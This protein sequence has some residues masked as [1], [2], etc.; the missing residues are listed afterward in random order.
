MPAPVGPD[1]APPPA[2]LPVDAA[3]VDA[4]C[5]ALVPEPGRELEDFV[6][7]VGAAPLDQGWDNVLWPVGTVRGEPVV[8]RVV[9][10]ASAVP[11][12]GREILVL[13]HLADVAEQL[14]MRIPTPLATT[15]HATLVPWI[16]GRTAGEVEEGSRVG[17][18]WSVAR[19]LARVHSLPA[20]RVDPNPV[21][22]AP[23]ATRTEAFAGDLERSGVDAVTRRRARGG[24]DRG[25]GATTWDRPA[26]LMHGD[27][28]PG[29]VVVP[30]AGTVREAALIDWG[31]ATIGDPASD[32]GALLL[33]DPSDSMLRAYRA[34]A[35]WAGIADEACWSAL[36][37]RSWAWGVRL[38]LSLLTAY[39]RGH[40]LGRAGQRLLD[41]C[42]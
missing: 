12:L 23:L 13:R 39:P 36:V 41:A 40:R 35:T 21:R 19:M 37:D 32:L 6:T 3:R 33:H 30:P 25:L 15:D 2:D 29:N 16:P 20:P 14:P 31:D 8:L 17:V 42:R 5:A 24:W 4:L 9:R 18:A 28:H 22:G 11:L 10:R 34:E 38:A 27:P 7:T 26:L 1:P